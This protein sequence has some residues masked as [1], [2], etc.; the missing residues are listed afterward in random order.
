M[1]LCNYLQTQNR[2]ASIVSHLALMFLYC[3][4][5]AYYYFTFSLK[6]DILSKL[7]LKGK[8]QL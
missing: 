6:H 3:K 5:A 4:Q 1:N 7:S 8:P 2:F